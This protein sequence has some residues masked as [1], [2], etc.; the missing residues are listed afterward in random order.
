[1]RENFK[2]LSNRLL[3]ATPT[4]LMLPTDVGD[5]GEHDAAQWSSAGIIERSSAKDCDG[6]SGQQKANASTNQVTL[7]I[8]R[9]LALIIQKIK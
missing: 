8:M 1:M 5:E 4:G 6:P 9:F 2:I 3:R 7:L